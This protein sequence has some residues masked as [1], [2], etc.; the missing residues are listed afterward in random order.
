MKIE[1][2][3]ADAVFHA[4]E[5]VFD[6]GAGLGGQRAGLVGEPF[7]N[8]GIGVGVANEEDLQAPQ[9]CPAARPGVKAFRKS[10]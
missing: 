5:V 1:I 8:L 4:G 10:M 2:G 3:R 9:R 7:G 6:V